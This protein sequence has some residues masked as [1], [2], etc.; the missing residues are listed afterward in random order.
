M[1]YMLALKEIGP[2]GRSILIVCT[3]T[4]SRFCIVPARSGSHLPYFANKIRPVN[5]NN[6]VIPRYRGMFR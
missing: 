2:M 1:H 6:V 3:P 4:W 5:A